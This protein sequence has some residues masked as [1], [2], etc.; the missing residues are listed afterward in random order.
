MFRKILFAVSLTFAFG[1][2]VLAQ[3]AP[4]YD[5]RLA[6][7]RVYSDP[8]FQEFIETSYG[9]LNPRNKARLPNDLRDSVASPAAQ[10]KAAR[11]AAKAGKYVFV[12]IQPRSGDYSGLL[13]ELSASAGFV[14]SGER[15]SYTKNAKKTRLVGWVPAEGVAAIRGNPGVAGL[16][17][18]RKAGRE[19]FVRARGF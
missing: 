12:S 6:G 18:L 7:S 14:L 3:A 2:D 19:S 8:G 15:V 9:Y 16:R 10:L 13:R 17:L 4:A 1:A 5:A 11:P